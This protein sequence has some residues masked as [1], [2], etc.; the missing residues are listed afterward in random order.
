MMNEKV[1]MNGELPDQILAS[2][3]AKAKATGI[4]KARLLEF[5]ASVRGYDSWDDLMEHVWFVDDDGD[6]A[7]VWH[8]DLTGKGEVEV[9]SGE[10]DFPQDEDDHAARLAETWTVNVKLHFFDCDT[11]YL[12]IDFGGDGTEFQLTKGQ[13]FRFA[14]AFKRGSQT[15]LVAAQALL[16]TDALDWFDARWIEGL[17]NY[18]V[19]QL[20]RRA[21]GATKLV[22][23]EPA[24]AGYGPNQTAVRIYDAG[25]RGLMVCLESSRMSEDDSFG[26]ISWQQ[27]DDVVHTPCNYPAMH[28]AFAEAAGLDLDL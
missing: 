15:E 26:Y 2:V 13:K 22:W 9:F 17:D 5:A 20:A 27:F 8:H 25:K 23:E 14:S 11:P 28:M 10:I 16:M 7:G 21:I 3:E 19:T 1:L 12:R 4:P 24:L 18:A 6:V